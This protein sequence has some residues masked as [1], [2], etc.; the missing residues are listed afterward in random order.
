MHCRSCTKVSG[1]GIP[2]LTRGSSSLVITLYLDS[3]SRNLRIRECHCSREA[4]GAKDIFPE[5]IFE[6]GSSGALLFRAESEAVHGL[7]L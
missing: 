6:T 7:L 3:C 4:R 5:K 1:S 2:R